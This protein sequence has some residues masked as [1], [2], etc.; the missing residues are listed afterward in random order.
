MTDQNT[1]ESNE[2]DPSAT[3]A[4]EFPWS[5]T[6]PPPVA[7]DEDTA[8][9][10][11][12][13]LPLYQQPASS[14]TLATAPARRTGGITAAVLAGALLLGGA[15][16]VGGAAWYDAWKG[17]DST[18]T[19][20]GNEPVTAS[21]A[22]APSSGSVE[23]VAATVLPS[24]VKINVSGSQGSGSG[25]GI[26]LSKDGDILTNNHVV[27]LASGG[28]SIT[29]SFNDGTTVKASVVGTDPVTDM[30]V[31]KAAG[32]KNLTPATIGHSSALKVGQSV[33]AV[34]SPYGLNSTV[35]TGIVSALNR[36]VSVATDEQQQL[37]PFG[38][39]QQQQQTQNDSTTYPA[40]QTDAAINPG[41]SGG[42]LVNMAGQ[43]VGVNSSIRT[44]DGTTSSGG[45]IGLGFAIP[46][47]EVLP[48]VQQIIKGEDP[49]HARLAITVS[50]VAAN[51]LTQGAEV[52]E[53]QADGAA[54]QAGLKSGDVITKVDDDVVDGSESLIATVR[55]HRPGDEV[56]LTYVRD[57]KTET[58]K[59]TLGSDANTQQS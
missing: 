50:D 45:S 23:K 26:V 19:A 4:S 33:V 56:T 41:N 16:G 38:L 13:P 43:V 20:S 48:I 1:P 27:S 12:Q 36:P 47:D 11:T 3:A 25:S 28:G 7:S 24:V 15:A 21:N 22:A 8:I 29:V 59:A 5:V 10:F 2:N 52:R 55:G 30:A 17:D 51:K 34:G 32:A 53:V 37:N 31:I 54:A 58:V 46:I 40:I 57:G 44:A 9:G 18:P 6:P 49:T 35:T 42:P 14:S 39:G